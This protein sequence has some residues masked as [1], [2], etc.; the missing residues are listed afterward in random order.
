MIIRVVFVA[1]IS[2]VLVVAPAKGQDILDS[3]IKK[4]TRLSAENSLEQSQGQ[5]GPMGGGWK[6]TGIS[7]IAV[8]GVALLFSNTIHDECVEVY[9]R[10]NCGDPDEVRLLGAI[11]AGGGAALLGIGAAK[12]PRLNLLPDVSIGRSSVAF[13]KRLSF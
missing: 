5:R 3:A 6:W 13:G 12:R 8:G 2:L 7:L 9:G 1:L 10:Y 4:T 11:I